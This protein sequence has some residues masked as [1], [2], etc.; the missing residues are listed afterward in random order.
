MGTVGRP[1]K[2]GE[3]VR[4][5]LL[6]TLLAWFLSLIFR[7]FLWSGLHPPNKRKSTSSIP[8]QRLKIEPTLFPVRLLISRLEFPCFYRMR[9][10]LQCFC[11]VLKC[12]VERVF[13]NI[14][15]TD[16]FG[17]SNIPVFSLRAN[18]IISHLT[19]GFLHLRERMTP[20]PFTP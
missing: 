12:L 11:V 16:E 18:L 1:G 14:S 7:R 3:M 9:P 6:V 19:R 20:Q 17:E 10:R 5:H 4:Y 15:I 8:K 2:D 13:G